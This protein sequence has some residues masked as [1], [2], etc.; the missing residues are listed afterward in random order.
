MNIKF[1][2]ILNVTIPKHSEGLSADFN[3][4][5]FH[6]LGIKGSKNW[7]NICLPNQILHISNIFEN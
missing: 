4:S 6:R 7:Q 2:D 3:N 5:S 1:S